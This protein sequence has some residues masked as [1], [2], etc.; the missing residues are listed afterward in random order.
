MSSTFNIQAY[1]VLM[2]TDYP[3]LF[4]FISSSYGAW[5]PV[6]LIGYGSG[7]MGGSSDSVDCFQ[8][9]THG[10]IRWKSS[11]IRN[12]PGK[13]IRRLSATVSDCTPWRRQTTPATRVS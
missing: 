10:P 2:L 4:V 1:L 7:F 9:R 5:K 12:D 3:M 11:K 6:K 8:G 13:V